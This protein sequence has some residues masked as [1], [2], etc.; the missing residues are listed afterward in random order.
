M[1][2]RSIPL[3]AMQCL[4]HSQQ[5]S[6]FPTML[7]EIARRFQSDICWTQQASLLCPKG[8]PQQGCR[9]CQVQALCGLQARAFC[10]PLSRHP[11]SSHSLVNAWGKARGSRRAAA[12]AATEGW[13]GL[14][15]GNE[16]N[17]SDPGL[18]RTGVREIVLRQ[19]PPPPRL[20]G[21]RSLQWKHMGGPPRLC[22]P[23]R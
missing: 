14:Q 13:S 6:E 4:D 19:L 12:A 1:S 23:K 11:L 15:V 10:G 21:H 5:F 3:H 8:V 7:S 22:P 18:R 2:S 16:V 9:Q 17:C 20:I